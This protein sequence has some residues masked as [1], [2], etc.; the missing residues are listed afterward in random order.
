M[1]EKT[2]THTFMPNHTVVAI[3]KKYNKYPQDKEQLD[4]LL[5]KFY[6]LNGKQVF[7]AGMKV[8][9]PLL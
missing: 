8:K 1:E 7:K 4:Y 3:I 9:V 5:T 6:E 2:I